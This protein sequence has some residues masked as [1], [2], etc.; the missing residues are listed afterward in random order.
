MATTPAAFIGHGNPMNSVEHNTWTDSWAQLGASMEAPSAILAISAHWY[1]GVSAVTAMKQPA[2]IHDFSGFP[3]ELFAVEYP[4]PGDPRLADRIVELAA[5]IH[6]GL[7]K[8]SWGL[9]HGTWSILT[10]L[11][12][13]AD[14]PVVQLSIHSGLSIEQHLD[15]ARTLSPLRDEGVLIMG[16]GNIVHNLGM[17]EWGSLGH[18]APW[19]EDFDGAVRHIM[20]TSPA[21]IGQIVSH[22]AF[23]LA[24]PTPEHFLP[25]VY[26]AGL[27][28]AAGTTAST[29]VEGC[30]LGSLSMTSYVI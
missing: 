30:D 13:A 9:D 23:S 16:S 7:D 24:V 27:A 5:P 22:P 10:H 26:L 18:G 29:L 17:I 2:T 6:V 11:R 1:V 20:T 19:A 8:D 25:I 4:A 15:L 21:D 28:D 12:P 14:V 3:D